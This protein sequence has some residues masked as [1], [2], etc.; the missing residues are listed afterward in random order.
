MKESDYPIWA[1]T[2]KCFNKNKREKKNTKNN[3]THLPKTLL[4]S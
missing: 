2:S 1:D 3:D 4:I